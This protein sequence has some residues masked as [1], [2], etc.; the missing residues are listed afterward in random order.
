MY[1]QLGGVKLF[2]A[3][4]AGDFVKHTTKARDTLC[5]IAREFVNG[6]PGPGPFMDLALLH[7]FV[8]IIHIACRS[9]SFFHQA[10][11]IILDRTF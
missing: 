3:W 2:K 9:H 1:E 7:E 4:A 11:P 8:L 5:W 6:R 10:H